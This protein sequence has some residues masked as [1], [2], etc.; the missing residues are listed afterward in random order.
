MVFR[1]KLLILKTFRNIFAGILSL[2]LILGSGGCSSPAPQPAALPDPAKDEAPAL[3]SPAPDQSLSV[4]RSLLAD[5]SSSPGDVENVPVG[6]TSPEPATPAP[7]DEDTAT[8]AGTD[9]KAA[10]GDSELELQNWQKFAAAIYQLQRLQHLKPRAFQQELGLTS[11][12]VSRIRRLQQELLALSMSLIAL[13]AEESI[14]QLQT[15]H[16]T[17]AEQWGRQL[18]DILTADQ[19]QS[20]HRAVI[21]QQEGAVVFLM[22]G[23]PERLSLTAQQREEVVRQL[24]A[25]RDTLDFS[26]LYDPWQW[27]KLKSRAAEARKT[28]E[29]QLTPEQAQIFQA[30]VSP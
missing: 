27:Q 29:R 30:I 12:Q 24:N 15:R 7:A 10:V 20:L 1:H 18:D 17:T 16:R 9:Q 23:I 2:V 11:Q 14:R 6:G 13:P 21:R 5:R 4:D 8:A 28:A 22:P 25:T 19:N 3:H 26:K